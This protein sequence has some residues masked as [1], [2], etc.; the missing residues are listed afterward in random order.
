MDV[1]PVVLFERVTVRAAAVMARVGAGRLGDPT[2][3]AEWTVQQLIDHMV[4]ST[5]YL[6]AVLAGRATV[7]R[8]GAWVDDYRN[9]ARSV[10]EA[11]R[12]PG[13]LD[14]MCLSPLGFTWSI[15][16]A[17]AGSFMD[18]LIHT[19]DLAT[20]T[21]QERT[22]DGELVDACVAMFLPE[23]PERGRSA[24]LVGPAVPVPAGASAQDRLLGAMGRQP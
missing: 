12:R 1:D 24:G 6:A 2:P 22:L 15:G 4:G 5:D 23:M 3:C 16:Q 10:L 7:A 17:T 9:G 13:V 20:A 21:D 18:N 11:L 19:W 14:R 8:S